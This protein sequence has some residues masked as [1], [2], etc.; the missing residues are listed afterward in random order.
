MGGRLLL[1]F[2]EGLGIKVITLA[3]FTVKGSWRVSKSRPTG[4]L[5]SVGTTSY[6]F[7]IT[8][9]EAPPP[10]LQMP[11]SP[12][13]PDFKLCTMWPTILAPD[14]LTGEKGQLTTKSARSDTPRFATLSSPQRINSVVIAVLLSS[15]VAVSH[16]MGCPRDT[17][18]PLTLTFEGSMSNIL[19]L[20]STTTLKAS[21]ISHMAMSSFFRP[22]ASR[23]W[24]DN[25]HNWLY[26]LALFTIRKQYTVMDGVQLNWIC[27]N[28]HLHRR[29]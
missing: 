10:P 14:I 7:W 18:P 23:A 17:A 9:D 12:Y 13:W 2:G 6:S 26:T 29:G 28:V 16:P 3:S 8:I 15:E 5:W 19:M 1:L 25:T 21:L 24:Q 4:G 11:A 20:A 27:F 22:A